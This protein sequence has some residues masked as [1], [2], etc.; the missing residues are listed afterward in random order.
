LLALTRPPRNDPI[1]ALARHDH[2]RNALLHLELDVVGDVEL[3][4]N[5]VG[6]L[7]RNCDEHGLKNRDQVFERDCNELQ[8]E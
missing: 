1:R 5:H 8:D 4:R 2:G 6:H 3:G 7:K